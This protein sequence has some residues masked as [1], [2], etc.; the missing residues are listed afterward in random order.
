[1]QIV[2]RTNVVLKF[3][4]N[5]DS[6]TGDDVWDGSAPYP[7]PSAAATTTL[8]SDS[9]ND[10]A[11]GT[12]AQTVVVKGL[13]GDGVE[14]SETVT[15][16]GTD[17]VTLSTEFWRINFMWNVDC[18][19]GEINAGNIQAKH[20]ATVISQMTASMGRT[21]QA[22][23][24]IPAGQYGRLEG[25]R[26][27]T[28]AN[29]SAKL[30]LQFR[31]EGKGWQTRDLCLLDNAANSANDIKYPAYPKFDAKTDFRVR[32]LSGANNM[33]IVAQFD[34]LLTSTPSV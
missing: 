4:R 28:D 31:P 17:A 26:C 15:M 14:V 29:A 21:L 6:D 12:G 20:G 3:G 16:D 18:G 25:W 24:T 32:V 19:S 22:V 1:M 8:V 2:D 9:T 5:S 30:L 11:A 10:T 23:Y 33:D 13:D 34:M 27:S 7:F